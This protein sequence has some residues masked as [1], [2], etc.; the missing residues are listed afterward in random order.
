MGLRFSTIPANP[1]QAERCFPGTSFGPGMSW[2]VVWHVGLSLLVS[3][4]AICML[5]F[6]YFL[7]LFPGRRCDIHV[8]FCLF[9]VLRSGG[10][11][12]VC[13]SVFGFSL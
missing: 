5:S 10:E 9:L 6:V 13:I 11:G 2:F 1:L 7:H 8:V 4:I 12:G 3:G